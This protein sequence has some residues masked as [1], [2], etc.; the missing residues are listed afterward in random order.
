MCTTQAPGP[1]AYKLPTWQANNNTLQLF[2][3]CIFLYMHL[4]RTL[5]SLLTNREVAGAVYP[6]NHEEP[7]YAAG[8]VG[9]GYNGRKNRIW[10]RQ[11]SREIRFRIES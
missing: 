7:G 2:I 6:T 4:R 11:H 3:F 5:C 8:E 1:L 10:Q 9:T